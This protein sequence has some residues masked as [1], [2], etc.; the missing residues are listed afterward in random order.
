MEPMLL[1]QPQPPTTWIAE[2]AVMED[3]EGDEAEEKDED[4]EEV[5]KPAERAARPFR[6]I[7]AAYEIAID[8]ITCI[9]ADSATA[10]TR[11]QGGRLPWHRA[12]L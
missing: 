10:A 1:P 4:D 7:L 11:P 2:E 5:L 6:A 9:M 8:L 3:K 12:R